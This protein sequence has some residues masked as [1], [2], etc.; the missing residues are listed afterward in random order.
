MFS[1]SLS[2]DTCV[3]GDPEVSPRMMIIPFCVGRDFCSGVC[4][5]G[6]PEVS[7]RSFP[8]M[9]TRETSCFPEDSQ[10][11]EG[12]LEADRLCTLSQNGYGDVWRP[13]HCELLRY[14]PGS[15]VS[16][17]STNICIVSDA[18]TNICI[19]PEH[20][21]KNKRA[22]STQRTSQAVPHPSTDRA[23]QRLASEFGRDPAYSL[24]YGRLRT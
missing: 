20:K 7:P 6:D 19:R 5:I 1:L 17:A 4:V 11:R 10:K 24:R 21:R 12:S 18:S 22:S 2:W 13:T 3:I 9:Y 8:Q 14:I 23:L 15:D 16:D